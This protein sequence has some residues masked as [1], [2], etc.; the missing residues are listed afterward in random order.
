MALKML[1]LRE[2]LKGT[3]RKMGN[4]LYDR[5]F[6][7][8][9]AS[10]RA[11]L[12]FP[13]GSLLSYRDFIS[14]S[15][16]YANALAS[17]GLKPGDR[18]ALRA[19]KSETCLMLY[20]AS[21][22]AGLVFLPLNTAYTG[23]ELEYFIRDSGA[24]LLICDKENTEEL[25]LLTQSAGCGLESIS[26]DNT[27]SLDILS[28]SMSPLFPTVSR[29]DEDLAAL[30]Y[31][32]GTTGRSKGAMLS[33]GNLLS[34]AEVL[35][36]FWKFTK[37]DILL[38]ALPI[39]HTHGL[40]VATNTCLA[41]GATMR[42]H[43][44]FD[45]ELLVRDMAGATCLM[46][47]PT[48]YT[49][50]LDW[51]NFTAE[52]TSSMRLFISGSA[53]LLAETHRQFEQRTGHRILERY[54]MTETNMSTSNPYDG[55]RRAGTVGR[56]LPGVEARIRTAEGKMAGTGDIGTLEVRG[57]NVFKGYWQMPE[58]TAEE[59]LPDG[60]FITGDLATVDADGYISIVGRGKDMIIS[61][62]FN[63]YPKEI[64]QVLDKV[65]GVLES[66]VIGVPHGDFGET[67][68]GVLVPAPGSD[69]DL[70]QARQLLGESLARYKHPRSLVVRP[71]LPRNAMGKVQKNLLRAEYANTFS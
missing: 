2:C 69:I 47:V 36:D 61:G 44:S 23:P 42:F 13:N 51:P 65:P 53:P 30:L 66:A 34:N 7:S 17:L 64:E 27:G 67:P 62:G 39:F 11:F 22:Q 12:Q 4:P 25:Q 18:I 3:L 1:L 8:N 71:S 5:L 28:E 41:A 52:S 60:F 21:V 10:D 38:H 54:G 15:S 9:Q 14:S 50:L 6:A 20:A 59:L 45:P 46:G 29:D 57:P 48:F 33:Q 56:P 35:A 55:E 40:F 70:E 19:Q 24:A 16:R 43:K 58:K 32:S 37:D 68:V 49:R 31:T 63:I 26:A